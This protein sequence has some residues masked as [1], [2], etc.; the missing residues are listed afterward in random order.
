LLPRNAEAAHFAA[1]AAWE[2]AQWATLVLLL[3]GV[4]FSWVQAARFDPRAEW[5]VF[6]PDAP[7]PA[8]I[9]HPP[10]GA[11]RYAGFV[12]PPEVAMPAPDAPPVAAVDAVALAGASVCVFTA[13]AC[14]LTQARTDAQACLPRAGSPAAR[15]PAPPSC[16]RAAFCALLAACAH[17]LTCFAAL[18]AGV[19]QRHRTA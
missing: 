8:S 7:L 9:T 1:A 3:L 10:G 15:C 18:L 2:L 4:C 17:A 5:F 11:R 13:L 12:A 6:P 16:W 19:R 14:V